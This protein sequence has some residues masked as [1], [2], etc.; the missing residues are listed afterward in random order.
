MPVSTP[1]ATCQC[2]TWGSHQAG[3]ECAWLGG[4]SRAGALH[5]GTLLRASARQGL[6]RPAAA[7]QRLVDGGRVSG[8]VGQL[9]EDAALPDDG[10]HE[11]GV[12]C[13]KGARLASGRTRDIPST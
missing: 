9:V 12:A 11:V 2:Q 6:G 3:L 7:L 10:V 4:G 5:G 1:P 8:Q 13:G